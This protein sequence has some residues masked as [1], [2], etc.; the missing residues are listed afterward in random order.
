V[1][2]IKKS[3]IDRTFVLLMVTLLVSG[4]CIPLFI[5]GTLADWMGIGWA[6]VGWSVAAFV[7]SA[8]ITFLFSPVHDRVRRHPA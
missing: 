2:N 3:L 4:A 6:A 1:E 7:I 8:V 5:I